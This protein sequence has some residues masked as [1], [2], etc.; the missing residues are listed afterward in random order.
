MSG[1]ETRHGPEELARVGAEAFDR[2]VRPMLRPEDDGK[3]VAIDVGTGDFEL[4]D[5]DYTAVVRLRTRSP[6]AEIWLGRVGAPA[7]YRIR[8]CP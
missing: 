5:D 4:D 1:T 6:R 2:R 3:F 7:A 8:R